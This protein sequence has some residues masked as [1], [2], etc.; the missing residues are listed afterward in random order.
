MGLVGAILGDIAGM[1]FEFQQEIDDWQ[2]NENYDVFGERQAG[3][4][5]T[6]D[7][8]MT[9]AVGMAIASGDLDF[10]KW[11]KKYGHDYFEVGYGPSFWNWIKS[12]KSEPYN[13]YGNGSAMRA[14]ACGQFAKTLNEAKYLA[15][16]SAMPTH[17]HPEGV[18]GA[19]VLASC[20][21]MAEHHDTYSKEDILN[22]AISEYPSHK[23]QFSPEIPI[24]E[25]EKTATFDV[26]CMGS[27]PMA[28]RCFYEYDDFGKMMRQI[29]RMFV[30]TDTIGA[31]AGAI[32]ESYYGKCT[33][34]D[35]ELL[36]RFLNEDLYLSFK[37]IQISDKTLIH[38]MIEKIA[39]NLNRTVCDDIA[40]QLSII[41]KEL[42]FREEKTIQNGYCP[43][44]QAKIGFFHKKDIYCFNCGQRFV[45]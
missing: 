44:C 42:S 21:W 25:Y 16:M 7:T 43:T 30:D 18:K 6:D 19:Q 13:S 20:V 29:N 5:F 45:R 39:P 24:K 27:V 33:D 22:Y 3:Q 41:E 38:E 31:I 9:I 23:Y 34:N 8:V 35:E 26:S 32:F 40:E 12:N 11:M 10:A 28:I 15:R 17:N 1:P 2:I 37:S 14:S 4:H 36:K